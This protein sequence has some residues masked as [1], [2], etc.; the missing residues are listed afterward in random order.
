MAQLSR[1]SFTNVALALAL[2]A[3]GIAACGDSDSAGSSSE[4]SGSES[5]SSESTDSGG[6]DG[7][8]GGGGGDQTIT[9]LSSWTTGNSTGDQVNKNI[10]AFTAATGIEVDI[11]EVNNDDVDETFEASALANEQPDLVI[12]N[13][14]PD[15]FEWL[16]QGLILDAGPYIEEWGIAE[17]VTPGSLEYWTNENGVNGFPYIGF[18]WPIWYNTDLLAQAGVDGVPETFDELLEA[19]EKLRAADIQPFALGGKDWTAQNFITWVGQQFVEPSDMETVF[20]EGNWCQ[21]DVIK[22]LDLMV[23]MRDNDVFVDNVAGYTSDQMTNAYFTGEAAMMPSGSWA[24]T[25]APPELAAVTE[26]AGLPVPEGSVYSEP[27]AFNGHSAG[28][29]I[30]PSAE[31]NIDAVRQ[32]MQHM[33]SSEV[34]KGWVGEASQILD[35]TPAMVEGATSS[36]PLVVAG[37]QLDESNTGWLLLPDGYLPAGT[38]W[39][40]TVAS[41]FF[42]SDASAED[43]CADLEN[44]YQN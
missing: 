15:T 19:S 20:S 32:F 22:G 28:F 4:G 30:T 40:P 29:Y 37:S 5:S 27:T 42:G 14:T 25:N 34:M 2:A 3:G 6:S 8:D 13:F 21:P 11:Q 1:T 16:P 38:D 26:L 12:L 9:I 10:E 23:Q 36:A 41:N 43:L 44:E 7:G 35:A 39:G 24:Y 17:A 33:Y 18:N 31:D